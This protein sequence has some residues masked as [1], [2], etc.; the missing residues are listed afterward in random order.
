MKRLT[1]ETIS[2]EYWCEGIE[3]VF[4]KIKDESFPHLQKQFPIKIQEACTTPN[5]QD[6]KRNSSH[7]IVKPL[8]KKTQNKD[9]ILQ[10]SEDKD[11]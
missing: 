9:K 11:Q 3:T 2:E 10:A 1:L 6:Q 5:I 7:H 4:N 8:I